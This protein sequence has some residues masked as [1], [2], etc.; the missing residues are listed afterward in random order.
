MNHR[1]TTIAIVAL[2]AGTPAFAG[3]EM[4]AA[5]NVETSSSS[6]GATGFLLGRL[7]GETAMDRMWSAATLYKDENNPILQEFALQGRHQMQFGFGDADSNDRYNFGA[8][9]S[10]F[11]GEHLEVR[12]ARYG[13]KSKWFNK[14]KFDGQINIWPEFEDAE[15]EPAVYRNLYDLYI[16][17]AASDAL[18]V[19]AGKTKVKFTRE[20]EISSKEILTIERSLLS[21]QLFPGELTGIW[22]NGK[23]I[24]GGWLY[25]AGLY[26]NDRDRDFSNFASDS[27]LLFLGKIGYDYGDAAGFD[28]AV[29]SVHYMYNSEPGYT[30]GQSFSENSPRFDHSFALTNDITKGRFGL[31]TDFYAALGNDDIAQPDVVGAT[32]IPSYYV[33]EGLQ[34][35]GRFQIAGANNRGLALY[36]RYEDAFVDQAGLPDDVSSYWSAYLGLN[37][38]IYGHK[39]KLMN[40]IEYS[41]AAGGDVYD[42]YTVFSGLRFSF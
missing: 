9:D 11:Y 40:G 15:G 21:N 26:S 14:F 3:P 27:G 28:S 29:A 30:N 32:F 16:T 24:A 23:D 25:E 35:V 7:S 5:E 12:R 38:Y 17:Y 33:A 22:A 37:Y 34:V 4:S 19:S 41:Q 42:G 2:L 31:V 13:F 20:Q 10:D 1:S 6:S 18:N 8:R 36:S 39:L